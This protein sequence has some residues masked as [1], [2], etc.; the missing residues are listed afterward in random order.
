MIGYR[1]VIIQLLSGYHPVIVRLSSGYVLPLLTRSWKC[2]LAKNRFQAILLLDYD[3][4]VSE[5]CKKV[6]IEIISRG[7]LDLSVS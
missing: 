7:K 1:P 6:K 3:K 5:E 4:W 2:H